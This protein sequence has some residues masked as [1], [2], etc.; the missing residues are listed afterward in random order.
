[1][2][3][4][5]PDGSSAVP[6]FGND[7]FSSVGATDNFLGPGTATV[8]LPATGGKTDIAFY[9]YRLTPAASLPTLGK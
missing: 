8:S 1:M 6:K 3:P 5:S 7:Q 2:W 9:C 4:Q